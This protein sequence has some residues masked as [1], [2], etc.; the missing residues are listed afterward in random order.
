MGQ[1]YSIANLVH[2]PDRRVPSESLA[3]CRVVSLACQDDH[4]IKLEAWIVERTCQPI[5]VSRPRT[6]LSQDAVPA[7][8]NDLL[9]VVDD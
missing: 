7:R 6:V 9:D 4:R 5:A 1:A 3:H 8:S 2:P